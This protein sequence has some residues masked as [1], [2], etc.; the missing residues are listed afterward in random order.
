MRDYDHIIFVAPIWAGKIAMPLTTFLVN[1]KANIA[2]YSFIT[3]CGGGNADQKKRIG[4]ELRAT[5]GKTPLKVVELWINNLLPA[6]KKNTVKYTSGYRIDPKEF[7]QFDAG[8]S[9]VISQGQ[10]TEK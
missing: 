9:E 7:Q 3:L 2:Q 10:T 5:I 6:E 1:E 8:I 4:D